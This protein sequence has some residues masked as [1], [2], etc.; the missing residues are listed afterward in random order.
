MCIDLFLFLY[1]MYLKGPLEIKKKNLNLVLGKKQ[2]K[3]TFSYSNIK[4]ELIY[5]C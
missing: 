2:C 3:R 5:Q 4:Q 1:C